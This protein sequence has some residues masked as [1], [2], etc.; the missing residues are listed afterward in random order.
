MPRTLGNAGLILFFMK[1]LFPGLL[2]KQKKAIRLL[3]GIKNDPPSAIQSIRG[4]S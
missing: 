1:V 4:I 3:A 2:L